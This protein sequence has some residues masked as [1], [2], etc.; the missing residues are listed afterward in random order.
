MNRTENNS[1][2]LATRPSYL[3]LFPDDSTT[4]ALNL[5]PFADV[6]ALRAAPDGNPDC[7]YLE[8]APARAHT[9]ACVPHKD[10]LE[11]V[12]S[13]GGKSGTEETPLGLLEADFGWPDAVPG[14]NFSH[15][16]GAHTQKKKKKSSH[17]HNL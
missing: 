2:L 12:L 14:E 17:I 8:V 9:R 16:A 3:R 15:V 7:S 6:D 1:V 5:R 4:V 10:R 13:G 11:D